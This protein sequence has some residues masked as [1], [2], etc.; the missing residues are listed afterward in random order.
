MAKVILNGFTAPKGF[1]YEDAADH[2]GRYV[3]NSEGTVYAI[4]YNGANSRKPIIALVSS[5]NTTWDNVIPGQ[6]HRLLT[7]GESFTVTI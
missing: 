7:S 4:V 1:S 3:V 5:P 6:G 2:V